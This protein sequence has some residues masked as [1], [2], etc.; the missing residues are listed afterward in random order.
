[1]P[2]TPVIKTTTQLLADI[3]NQIKANGI[4]AITGNMLGQLLS[5]ITA[6]LVNKVENI[7]LLGLQNYDA[8]GRQYKGGVTGDCCI[9]D[10]ML[11]QCVTD[12]QGAFVS[13]H[14]KVLMGIE[15]LTRAQLIAKRD[16]GT[17]VPG[18]L[19]NANDRNVFMRA[20]RENQ[21]DP[22]CVRVYRT[23]RY[24]E[25][26]G[27]SLL[28]TV[29]GLDEAA[30]I[31]VDQHVVY[32]GYVYLRTNVTNNT[33]APPDNTDYSFVPELSSLYKDYPVAISY[34]IDIDQVTD[35]RDGYGNVIVMSKS[36]LDD[37]SISDP[38]LD[39]ARWGDSSFANNVIYHSY[40]D[41]RN[42]AVVIAN[43]IIYPGASIQFSAN[44][45]RSSGF[46]Q[47]VVWQ[48]ALIHSLTMNAS[49]GMTNCNLL[50]GADFS[51]HTLNGTVINNF[52]LGIALQGTVD[53]TTVDLS[54]KII[55]NH[56]NTAV[57]ELDLDTAITNPLG[58]IFE[59]DIRP[60][61][62]AST[63]KIISGTGATGL[64]I[65]R[66]KDYTGKWTYRFTTNLAS[67]VTFEDVAANP[68]ESKLFFDASDPLDPF[69]NSAYG[70]IEFK[71]VQGTFDW[72]CERS[73]K[74]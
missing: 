16:A 28:I 70:F 45:S 65:N 54:D 34:N 73:K 44:S 61:W 49:S 31:V 74:I 23:P 42:T 63:I 8:G 35:A 55:T 15:V 29:W 41:A 71:K 59:V 19:Y 56:Y 46:T 57:A 40:V 47:N 24:N 69:D 22:R 11:L 30:S 62:F 52:T 51:G 21:L 58:T 43:N 17:L 14:W 13:S 66:I 26:N 32:Q 53:F 10:G 67:I 2:Y 36:I 27:D 33:D 25:L 12:T 18:V 5:D 9:K 1:M 38:F 37:L 7:N 6:S 39:F 50:Q 64:K 72:I 4:N 68:S 48:G 20:A 3:D 60:V